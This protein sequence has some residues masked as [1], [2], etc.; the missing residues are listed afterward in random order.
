MEDV[1]QMI[2]GCPV[3]THTSDPQ[4][5]R[6]KHTFKCCSC[7]YV[8]CVCV[9]VQLLS[10][11][12]RRLIM[13]QDAALLRSPDEQIPD[14]LRY[15]QLSGSSRNRLG[16]KLMECLVGLIRVYEQVSEVGLFLFSD[17]LVLTRRMVHHTPFTLAHRSTH[18]F[19]ASVALSSLAV[20]EITHSRCEFLLMKKSKYR[21]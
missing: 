13:T 9:C 17:A 19:Q 10:E 3:N 8:M 18:A 14:S 2:Q 16:A 21:I 7:D 20:R 6:R 15:L 4:C 12:N 5:G 1:Q 11:G